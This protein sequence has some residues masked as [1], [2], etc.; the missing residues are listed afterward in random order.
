MLFPYIDLVSHWLL[1]ALWVDS[2]VPLLTKAWNLIRASLQVHLTAVSHAVENLQCLHL[3]PSTVSSLQLLMQHEKRVE[4]MDDVCCQA[5]WRQF[6]RTSA[7]RVS[8]N[9]LLHG[10]PKPGKQACTG[11]FTHHR[12]CMTWHMQISW[13]FH[14]T[15]AGALR[16]PGHASA[17]ISTGLDAAAG[18]PCE[19]SGAQKRQHILR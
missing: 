10:T 14:G 18:C 1:L 8:V 2:Y 4:M 3:G 19:I 9:V 7:L 5:R 17:A 12:D 11:K 15:A 6:S 13:M 16:V